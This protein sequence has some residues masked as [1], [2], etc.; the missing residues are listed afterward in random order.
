MIEG[1][2]CIKYKAHL[3]HGF[4][5]LGIICASYIC[6]I[7][8]IT[9]HKTGN[10]LYTPYYLT[11]SDEKELIAQLAS[12]EDETEIIKECNKYAC[13]KLSFH[14]KNNLKNKEANCVG[15]AQYTTALLNPAFKYKGLL[16]KA[17]PVV[18]QVHLYGFNLHPLAMTIMPNKLKSFFKDHDF[19]EIRSENGEVVFIDT[20]LQDLLGTPFIQPN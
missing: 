1:T 10:K 8:G 19:V 3:I 20:S 15:Y 7:H 2:G 6:F 18:G 14:R 5:L 4:I 13:K 9:L 11:V 16:S 12:V 17:R